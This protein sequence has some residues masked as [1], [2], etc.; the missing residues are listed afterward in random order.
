MWQKRDND[1][2]DGTALTE[3]RMPGVRDIIGPRL[4]HFPTEDESHEVAESQHA[5]DHPE[6]GEGG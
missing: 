3:G 5:E 6:T 1:P 2:E 4:A